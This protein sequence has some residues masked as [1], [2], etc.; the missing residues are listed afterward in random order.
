MA[1]TTTTNLGLTK[2]EVGS[3]DGTWGTKMNTNLDTIDTAVADRLSKSA[4]GAISAD[5]T[6]A[7]TLLA[8]ASSGTYHTFRKN[9]TANA[10]NPVA[11]VQGN[12][13]ATVAIFYGVTGYGANAANA[14]M[15]VGFDN[16]T[17]RSIKAGGTIAGSG[18][19]AAEYENN[20]G[21][22]IVKGQIVGFDANGVLTDRF[23]AAISFGVKSTNPYLVGGDGWGS[24]DKVGKP[25]KQPAPP[26]A[27]APLGERATPE[28]AQAHAQAVQAH[29][30]ALQAY[31]VALQEYQAEK[32][33]F[34][35][36]LEAARQLVDRIAYCGK[37]PCNVTGAAPGDYIVA[38]ND[39]SGGIKGLPVRSPTFH[40]Y[41]AAVGRVNRILPDGRAEIAVIVH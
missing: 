31:A 9:V 41:R 3:S 7:G 37:V 24:E 2:P 32:S 36:R 6:V 16:V 39:G 1:D 14:A 8:G 34:D 19:D 29:E 18:A 12:A 38:V 15:G 27:P 20:G 23:D 40:Q 25:P 10:G 17:N 33:A 35:A 26:Q 30:Q 28:A 21:L 4:G 11:E 22:R 13:G 5:L